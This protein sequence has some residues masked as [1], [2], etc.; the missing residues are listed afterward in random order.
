MI[1]IQLG[2]CLIVLSGTSLSLYAVI[3]V[4][5][6]D[7]DARAETSQLLSRQHDLYVVLA[8]P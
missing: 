4:P 2:A 7:A 5:I 8:D 6:H 3:I 1:A